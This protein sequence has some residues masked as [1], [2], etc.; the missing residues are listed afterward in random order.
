MTKTK[1][2]KYSILTDATVKKK[3]LLKSNDLFS[4]FVNRLSGGL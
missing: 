4:E 3:Q 2:L 1:M